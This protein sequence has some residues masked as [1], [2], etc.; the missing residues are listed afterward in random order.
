[1]R[2]MINKTTISMNNSIDIAINVY[3]PLVKL[4]YDGKTYVDFP[5]I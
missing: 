1:M 2:L 4:T 3:V 5:I